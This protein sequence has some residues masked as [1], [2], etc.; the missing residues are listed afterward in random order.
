MCY[1]HATLS[2][3]CWQ[4]HAAVTVLI[5]T[6]QGARQMPWCALPGPGCWFR[7]QD[8]F[9]DDRNIHLV[10]ELCER[11]GILNRMQAQH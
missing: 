1:L 3:L 11:G 6:P 8:V 2:R 9:E 4:R 5:S 7:A 10:M